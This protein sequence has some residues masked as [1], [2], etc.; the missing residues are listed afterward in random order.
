[1]IDTD[2]EVKYDRYRNRRRMAWISFLA[3]IFVGTS[4]L[5][6]GLSADD[7]AARVDTMSFFIGTVF[8][9]W[10]AVVTWYFGATTLT[11]ATRPQTSANGK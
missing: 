1:M 5:A 9:V 7:R 6:F 8:G 4:V 11:D 3:I 10:V 2:H